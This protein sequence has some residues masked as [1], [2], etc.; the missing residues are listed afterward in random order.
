MGLDQRDL[1]ERSLTGVAVLG[2][3][4]WTRWPH[5][6]YIVDAERARPVQP[7]MIITTLP[8]AYWQVLRRYEEEDGRVAFMLNALAPTDPRTHNGAAV[9]LFGGT[10]E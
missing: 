9:E 6:V 8:G 1:V 4:A 10:L 7:G 2:Q 5:H 3:Q